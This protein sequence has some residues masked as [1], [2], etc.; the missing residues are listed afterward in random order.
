MYLRGQGVPKD[1]DLAAD[2]FKKACDAG[3]DRGCE[4]LA[5]LKK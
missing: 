3:L 5:R 2:L 1:L 4:N